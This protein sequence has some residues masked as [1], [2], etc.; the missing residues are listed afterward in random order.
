ML[1]GVRNLFMIGRAKWCF[2]HQSV[3]IIRG[4]SEA[5]RLIRG[6]YAM[7]TLQGLVIEFASFEGQDGSQQEVLDDCDDAERFFST[8]KV[9]R[10]LGWGDW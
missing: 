3:G 7:S 5:G 6:I 8:A 4:L 10:R 9:S 2:S 1:I